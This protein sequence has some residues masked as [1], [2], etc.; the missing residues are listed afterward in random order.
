MTDLFTAAESC[1]TPNTAS[2]HEF[3]M[4]G[5]DS[6]TKIIFSFNP[7][8]QREWF[9]LNDLEVFVPLAA[10]FWL[11]NV[12]MLRLMGLVQFSQIIH[13]HIV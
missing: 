13:Q 7:D 6:L 2:D 4:L 3:N 9:S 10:I 8:V 12:V 5:S 11:G 1:H